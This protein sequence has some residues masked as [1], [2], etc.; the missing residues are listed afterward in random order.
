MISNNN[1]LI[2]LQSCRFSIR[3]RVLPEAS[4]ISHGIIAKFSV[5]WEPFEPFMD[6]SE[7]SASQSRSQKSEN[8]ISKT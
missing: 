2:V 5:V 3:K 1:L 8:K 4:T 6:G 7:K